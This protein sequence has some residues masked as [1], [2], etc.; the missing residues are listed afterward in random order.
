MCLFLFHVLYDKVVAL[1]PGFMMLLIND[2]HCT[3]S[4]SN[5]QNLLSTREMPAYPLAQITCLT[6]LCWTHHFLW[7][8]SG[9]GRRHGA[10]VL[11]PSWSFP[12]VVGHGRAQPDA[13]TVTDRVYGTDCTW[14][15]N[16]LSCWRCRYKL[17]FLFWFL[18]ICSNTQSGFNYSVNFWIKALNCTRHVCKA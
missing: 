2:E 8:S 9:G 4:T 12:W 13:A 1:Q 3:I 17:D 10:F 14:C 18:L 16:I 7:S 6:L 15:V 11:F 5:T